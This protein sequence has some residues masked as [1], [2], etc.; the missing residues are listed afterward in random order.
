MSVSVA[1]AVK[2]LVVIAAANMARILFTKKVR[3]AKKGSSSAS[4]GV[5]TRY[6]CG[7]VEGN[8]SGI[9][10]VRLA[11]GTG[12]FAAGNVKG[13]EVD[14]RYGTGVTEG[15]RDGIVRVRLPFGTGYFAAS[16]LTETDF[17]CVI[18][19]RGEA[20]AKRDGSLQGTLRIEC[21]ISDDVEAK[22]GAAA[23]LLPK[24][25]NARVLVYCRSGR[26]AGRFAEGLKLRGY[27][28]VT[29]GACKEF[30]GTVGSA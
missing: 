8:S 16:D 7:V 6:G 19:V 27:T 13:A 17:N 1:N 4:S 3:A 22:L 14:T 18:D 2:A 25:K 30:I 9:I 26:R 5:E 20:E 29:T 28:N 24:D 12:F 11:F 10:K 23:G 15:N 21:G